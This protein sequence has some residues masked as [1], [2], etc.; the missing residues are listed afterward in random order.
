MDSN[1]NPNANKPPVEGEIVPQSA[2]KKRIYNFMVQLLAFFGAILMWFYVQG[3]D[4]PTHTKEF[5]NI[6]VTII[7]ADVL[8][9]QQGY[10]VLSGDG[11]V[12]MTV[13]ITVSGRRTDISKLKNSDIRVNADISMVSSIGN[14][15]CELTPELPNGLSVAGMS[16][17]Y[18]SLYIDR[19]VSKSIPI[20]VT[21]TGFVT[22]GLIVGQ[23]I[24]E[25]SSVIVTGPENVINS[26]EGAYAELALD[27][28]SSSINARANLIL[29]NASGEEIH[30][31]YLTMKSS[32]ADIYIP[33]YEEKTVPLKVNFTGGIYNDENVS[34]SLN[35]SVMKIRGLVEAVSE[36]NEITISIDESQFID[37]EIINSLIT[38]PSGIENVDEINVVEI[39]IKSDFTTK[40]YALSENNV[41]LLNTPSGM[42]CR[43]S[44]GSLPINIE[45]YGTEASLS[46][47]DF[48]DIDATVDLSGITVPG[49]YSLNLKIDT[50]SAIYGVYCSNKYT[51][52]IDVY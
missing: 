43:V 9:E 27:R 49:T 46:Y 16:A 24:A 38:L 40:P 20:K 47:F 29:K 25:P 31:E 28:I 11:S 15:S 44:E 5:K 21:R 10:T 41:R 33:V 13:D 42:N 45:L 32:E 3:Y 23:P 22:S 2:N 14:V 12:S 4:S 7:G 37:D 19:S 35:P 39:R 50:G 8:K 36:I 34:V 48:D 26:I 51:I 6:P 18:I 52:K 30:N 17:N 1:Q